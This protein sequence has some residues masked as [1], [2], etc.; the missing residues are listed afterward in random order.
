MSDPAGMTVNDSEGHLVA[1][2]IVDLL[3]HQEQE[4]IYYI[5][6]VPE[7]TVSAQEKESVAVHEHSTEGRIID[8][9]LAELQNE[10][11]QDSPI[12]RLVHGGGGNFTFHFSSGGHTSLEEPVAESCLRIYDLLQLISQ[13][14]QSAFLIKRRRASA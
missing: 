12:L 6:F 3:D 5:A 4:H 7:N 1:P 11:G 14:A 8:A 2:P 13:A 9:C 10:L